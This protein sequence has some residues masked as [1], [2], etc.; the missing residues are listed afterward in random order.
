ME[1][2]LSLDESLMLWLNTDAF[3]FLDKAMW[4]FSEKL[5]W[6]PV[7]VLLLFSIY[8]KYG[9]KIFIWAIIFIALSVLLNDQTASGLFKSWVAR[10]RPSH[11]PGIEEFLHFVREPN[12]NLYK[13][14]QF[15]FYSSHAANYA[16]VVTFYLLLMRPRKW[17]KA[18]L[19]FW[20]FLISYSRIYLGVHFPSDI[21]MGL[22]MGVAY[23]WICHFIFKTV[24]RKFYPSEFNLINRASSFPM[25]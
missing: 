12:G 24:L 3:P 17:I 18:F 8:K 22:L 15:G 9:T 16:G 10:P 19:V 4:Y 14:G 7:Y 1:F 25:S 13:G 2:F 11:T 21:L 23:G 20:V 6:I 5:F